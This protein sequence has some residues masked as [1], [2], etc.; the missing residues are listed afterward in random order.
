MKP[1][2]IIITGTSCTGKTTLGRSI[3]QSLG[4]S[5]IDLDELHF[6]PNWVAKAPNVFIS[7]V[8]VEIAELDEWIVSGSYQSK[9]KDNLWTQANII[10]WL[11]LPL[12]TIL[13]RYF[14]RTFRRVVFKEKCCG[15]NYETLGH[16]L[17]KDNMLLHIFKTYWARKRR[18]AVWRHDEFTDKI[19]LVP[20][21]KLDVEKIMNNPILRPSE[22]A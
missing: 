3:A 4:I 17:F 1:R 21:T 2:R 14:R 9:L 6:L 13:G 18:L 11:D 12:G 5:Q 16:V 19:W 20:Q 7:D 8:Q 15:E 10:I 22:I